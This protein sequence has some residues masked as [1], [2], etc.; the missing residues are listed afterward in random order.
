MESKV[1]YTATPSPYTPPASDPC[2]TA[3]TAGGA[4]SPYPASAPALGPTLYSPTGPEEYPPPAQYPSPPPQY[5]AATGQAPYEQPHGYEK[6][7]AGYPPQ[8]PP[9]YETVQYYASPSQQSQQQQLVV[10][11]SDGQQHHPVI[12]QQVPSY[13]RHIVFA[14][15]VF[16][17]C[18]WLFGLIAFILAG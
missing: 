5:P 10:V 16:W 8:P 1:E 15:L 17:F 6:P 13:V 18:N 7:P 11:V 2:L 4:T 12:V 14:C 9:A 3:D